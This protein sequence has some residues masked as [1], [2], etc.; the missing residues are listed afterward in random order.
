MNLW[1]HQVKL[2]D[3]VRGEFSRGNKAVCCVMPTG[4]GKTISGAA[5]VLAH[6]NK[7][8]DGKCL[9]LAHREEL[10]GQAFDELTEAGL[11]CG[12]IQSVPVRECNPHR[13]VQVASIQTLIARGM[14]PNAS[15]LVYDEVHHSV[16]DSWSVIPKTYKDRGVPIIGLTATPIRN[17]GRG[18]GDIFDSIVSPI[19]ARE[20]IEQGFL[21]PF[22]LIHPKQPLRSG[23]I[24]QSPVDAYLQHA[25]GR[26]AIVFAGNIPAATAFR[27]QFRLIGLRAELV[28][29][30]MPLGERRQI[31]DRYKSGDL[32][33]L[34]NVAVLTEGFDDRPTD[35]VIIARG[36]GSLALYLQICGRGLRCSPET[37]KKDCVILDLHGATHT[38]GAPDEDRDWSESLEGDGINHRK[39]EVIPER[40]CVICGVTVEGDGT[41]CA[42][43]G[44][45]RPD[46]LPPD[47][48]GVELVR[49]AA[50]RREGPID[51]AR[52]LQRWITEGIS[53]GYAAGWAWNKFRAVY[54]ATP[55]VDVRNALKNLG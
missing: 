53:K 27:D 39:K 26:K 47:V 12:V 31:L 4:T 22:E 35:C 34:T 36:V 33:V 6:L 16:S 44:I 3:Q 25:R 23:Q 9:W 51:R 15:F 7:K 41:V 2:L 29:G 5:M 11:S 37:G 46:L 32:D 10:V 14:M 55:D 13:P 50:K 8:A 43:C 17:D 1:P 49:Y 42:D 48:V 21:V 38:H 18:L 28:T 20:A 52:T 19:S 40:F 24:A 54:G 30:D 45:A